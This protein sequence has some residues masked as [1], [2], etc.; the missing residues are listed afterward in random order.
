MVGGERL[1]P[2]LVLLLS[3]SVAEGQPGNDPERAE[4]PVDTEP[5]EAPDRRLRWFPP[6]PGPPQSA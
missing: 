4:A 3:A 2:A 1:I 5:E 6:A